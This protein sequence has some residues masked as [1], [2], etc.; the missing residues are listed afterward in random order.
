MLLTRLIA[1][2]FSPGAT[3]L[4]FA[5][6]MFMKFE[7]EYFIGQPYSLYIN[8]VCSFLIGIALIQSARKHPESIMAM[9][10]LCWFLAVGQFLFLTI[11]GV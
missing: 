2:E 11:T 6:V 9:R 10:F 8:A 3:I 4:F 5:V 7:M 1:G